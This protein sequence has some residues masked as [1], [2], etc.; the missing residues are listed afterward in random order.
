VADPLLV[1]LCP[2]LA[3]LEPPPGAPAV[4]RPGFPFPPR[5]PDG[6]NAWD[7][8][9]AIAAMYPRLPS[10]LAQEL[11]SRLRPAAPP[12]DGFPLAGHPAVPKALIYATDDEFFEP[13]WERFMAREV[14][15][16]EPIEIPGGHFPMA[17]DPDALAAL[18]ERLALTQAR[19]FASDVPGER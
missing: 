9:A 19:Y 1:Y 12:A 15:G 16:I 2:R 14:L 10:D 5:R 3:E 17:E 4:F 13:G 8:D 7:P 11:A 6:A 18:L